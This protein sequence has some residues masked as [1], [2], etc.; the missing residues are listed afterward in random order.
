MV[1]MVHGARLMVTMVQG[2]R[3]SDGDDD[4]GKVV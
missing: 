4:A 1:T 3:L 2:A